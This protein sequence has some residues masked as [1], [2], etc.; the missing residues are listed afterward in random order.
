MSQYSKTTKQQL[1]AYNRTFSTTLNSEY[2]NAFIQ[3]RQS[4]VNCDTMKS[5]LVKV[6]DALSDVQNLAVSVKSVVDKKKTTVST[7]ENRLISQK[8]E[9]QDKLKDLNSINDTDNASKT[10]RKNKK[11]SMT[12]EYFTLAYY[13]LTII[14]VIFLLHKQYKFSAL[15]FLAVFLVIL[16]VIAGLAWWGIPYN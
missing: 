9:F 16:L 7:Y 11:T 3:C 6:Q 12:Y 4:N 5:Q 2:K 13:V 14:L 10:L 1:N 8:Q 15:Y